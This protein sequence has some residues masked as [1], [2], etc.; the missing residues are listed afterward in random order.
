[1]AISTQSSL[2]DVCFEVCTALHRIGITAVLTGGSAA[3]F[4]APDAYQSRDADFII[5]LRADGGPRVLAGLGYAE[6][7]GTFEHCENAYT[8]EFPRG[9]LAV[10]D[11]LV[12]TWETVRRG[13]QLLHVLS[14]T[15]C[16]RDRLMWFYASNDRSALRAAIGVVGSG[17]VNRDLIMAWSLR[18][19]FRKECDYFFERIG[20]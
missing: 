16:V 19:G 1:M 17:S 10:G 20:Q 14:R 6:D 11:D 2:T 7:G 18:E 12:G 15:D 8:L 4:Y 13:D 9:P 3:T 5:T